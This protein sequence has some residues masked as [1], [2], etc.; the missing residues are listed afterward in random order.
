M[1]HAYRALLVDRA[2]PPGYAGVRAGH[3]P[4]A[5]HEC[6][7]PGRPKVVAAPRRSPDPGGSG[8]G[9]VRAAVAACDREM[10]GRRDRRSAG[11]AAV[12]GLSFGS[13]RIRARCQ[14]PRARQDPNER[15]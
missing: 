8:A 15:P 7:G 14:G 10:N 11:K 3:V 4:G 6:A 9:P 12:W 13:G 5:R 1:T 2:G